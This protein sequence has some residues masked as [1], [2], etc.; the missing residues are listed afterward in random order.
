MAHNEPGRTGARSTVSLLAM[1]PYQVFC[2]VTPNQPLALPHRWA[3]TDRQQ[4]RAQSLWLIQRMNFRTPLRASAG[5]GLAASLPF[6]L[7]VS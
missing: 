6:S 2:L 7:A 5:V 3:N 4:P 1:E